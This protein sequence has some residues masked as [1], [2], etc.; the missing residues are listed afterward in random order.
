MKKRQQAWLIRAGCALLVLVTLTGCQSRST[1]EGL[2][3][4]WERQPQKEVTFAVV[5]RLP[6]LTEDTDFIKG[7]HL[8]LDEVNAAGGAGGRRV[9]LREYHDEASVMQ[10]TVIAQELA[11][12]PDIS[13]V[14]GHT[15]THVT[16]PAS[17][18]YEDARLLML[19]PV[20]SNSRLTQR[21]YQTI[22]QSIPGDDDIGRQMA[23]YAHRQGY[24]RILIYYADN[25]YGRGLA[26][27]FEDAAQDLEM[28][29]VD[30]VTHFHDDTSFRRAL[31][32]WQALDFE[33][34]FIADSMRTGREFV[35]RLQEAGLKPPLLADAGMDVNFIQTFGDYAEGA[36]LASLVNPSAENPRMQAF[37][38]AYRA[39]HGETPDE[40]AIQ[41]YEAIHLLSQAVAAAESPVPYDVA[42]A[43]RHISWEGLTGTLS[44]D[45]TGRIEGKSIYQKKVVNGQFIYEVL[46][47]P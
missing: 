1:I 9:Q 46:P 26:N 47:Q 30:R 20:V 32:R 13:A 4:S 39:L 3:R 7:A 16:L 10:G 41:G 18:I 42:Q 35:L 8:A 17:T 19:S 36:V 2:R 44:F 38:E 12:D 34:V 33:A 22:F 40:W 25:D 5:G 15:S 24:R 23:H 6:F 37:Q 45:D 28:V 27:A 29:I 43:L 11:A 21:G 14:I 31:N